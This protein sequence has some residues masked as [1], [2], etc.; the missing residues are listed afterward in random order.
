MTPTFPKTDHVE[1]IQFY[2]SVDSHT[3]TTLEMATHQLCVML[4]R[5]R[6]LLDTVPYWSTDPEIPENGLEISTRHLRLQT[7]NNSI[8]HLG[9]AISHLAMAASYK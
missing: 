7:I 4:D 6:Q 2:G 8:R 5:R 3:H 1:H 9:L